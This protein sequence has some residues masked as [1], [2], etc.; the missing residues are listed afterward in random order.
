MP[1]SQCWLWHWS[2]TV[3]GIELMVDGVC[4]GKIWK[5]WTIH[6][7]DRQIGRCHL[8][9]LSRGV[10]RHV[11][12]W[13]VGLCPAMSIWY[14]IR[15]CQTF[16]IE[17]MTEERTMV[18]N[19]LFNIFLFIFVVSVCMHA[20]MWVDLCVNI[21]ICLYMETCVL[22]QMPEADPGVFFDYSPLWGRIFSE[23]RV[24]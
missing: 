1:L 8:R 11:G 13:T 3:V 19:I 4:T 18:M 9:S 24:H 15:H 22:M 17:P 16:P 6:Q 23:V 2:D 12:V 20:Y 21:L 5:I 10:E 14:P 7:K